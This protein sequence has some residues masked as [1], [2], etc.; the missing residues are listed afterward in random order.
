ML[1]I[2]QMKPKRSLSR[3]PSQRTSAQQMQMQMKH[4][5]PSSRTYVEHRSIAV[6]DLTFAGDVRSNEM[7]LADN[8]R[9][10]GLGFF[11]SNDVLFRN[12]EN[13]CGSLR[14]D[15][16]KDQGLTVFVDFFCG[17]FT[18][19]NAA[20]KTIHRFSSGRRLVRLECSIRTGAC[21]AH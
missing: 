18:T 15:V 10:L 3:R 17:N 11:H 13:V 6:L 19:N 5:L 21:N 1:D 16:L 2:S 7:A 4:R 8:L 14:V 20:E 12:D 9:V